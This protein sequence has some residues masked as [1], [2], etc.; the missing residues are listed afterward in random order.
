VRGGCRGV[1]RPHRLGAAASAAGPPLPFHSRFSPC[2]RFHGLGQHDL[3]VLGSFQGTMEALLHVTHAGFPRAGH[4]TP[5]RSPAGCCPASPQGRVR[6]SSR[7]LRS[8]PQ[9]AQRYLWDSRG[10]CCRRP[11][12]SC[13]CKPHR[14]R[15]LTHHAVWV[16]RACPEALAPRRSPQTHA[17]RLRKRPWPQPLASEVP[18]YLLRIWGLGPD[19]PG[20]RD[21]WGSL[22][23]KWIF[24]GRHLILRWKLG[25][26]L[27][28]VSRLSS[29]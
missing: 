2:S 23:W 26:S 9:E 1:L 24:L 8:P 28:Q 10:T 14:A 4:K 19:L 27:S 29:C 3:K 11:T 15:L 7:F 17:F 21:T 25:C 5:G 20:N 22:L 6:F 16:L 18:K 13:A 12:R